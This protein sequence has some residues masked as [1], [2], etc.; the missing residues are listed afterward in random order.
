MSG[1]GVNIFL[2]HVAMLWLSASSWVQC[3][4]PL[5]WRYTL[6][7]LDQEDHVVAHER[8]QIEERLIIRANHS[9]KPR[10]ER[11]AVAPD[12]RSPA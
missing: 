11:K 8:V 12:P 5:S 6:L 1:V 3:L 9:N 2:S 4:I 7:G 10:F